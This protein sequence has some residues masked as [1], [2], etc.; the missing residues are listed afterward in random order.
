MNHDVFYKQ[1]ALKQA[2]PIQY[3]ELDLSIS[4]VGDYIKLEMVVW[5]FPKSRSRSND[6]DYTQIKFW[7]ITGSSNHNRDNLG[8]LVLAISVPY[9]GFAQITR[10]HLGE[11]EIFPELYVKDEPYI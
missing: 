8:R 6:P 9:G 5:Q 3:G 10:G 11:C 1:K 7:S 2:Y 4:I